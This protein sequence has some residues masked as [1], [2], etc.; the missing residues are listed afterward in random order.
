MLSTVP[1]TIGATIAGFPVLYY[2]DSL[3]QNK[4]ISEITG[5][6]LGGASMTVLDLL[7][8]NLGY[9]AKEIYNINH[10]KKLTLEPEDSNPK[11]DNLPWEIK[12]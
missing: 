12:K 10:T 8:L 3:A 6:C 4:I 5:C 9:A 1:G 11:L 7:C 2:L